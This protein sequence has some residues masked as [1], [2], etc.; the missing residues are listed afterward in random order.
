VVIG[1]VLHAVG[2]LGII[3]LAV[4][5][6]LRLDLD[7]VR[8]SFVGASIPL[9]VTGGALS[10]L[11]L[12]LQAAR[13]MAIV[14]PVRP[15]ARLRDAFFTLVAGYTVGMVIPARAADLVRAHLMA[16][17]SGGSMATL[18]ATTVVDHLL[19]AVSLFVA[20]GIFAALSSLPLWLRTAGIAVCGGSIAGLFGL[21]LLRPRGERDPAGESASRDVPGAVHGVLARLREGLVAVG[22]PRVLAWASFLAIGGWMSELLIAHLSLRAFGLPMGVEPSALVLLATTVSAAASI[23][24]GNAGA[25]Q[26]ACIVALSGFEVPQEAALAFGIAYHAAHLVPTALVGGVWLVATG[27]R[28]AWVRDS[29]GDG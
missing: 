12:V 13:W 29:V 18:T 23:S 19:A 26:I 24:P 11:S 10:L 7:A 2:L 28:S 16:R 27:Y 3:A 15:N 21:W 4:L 20:I 14:H 9:L 6:A 22:R 17:R 25:F 5:A 1:R 8:R